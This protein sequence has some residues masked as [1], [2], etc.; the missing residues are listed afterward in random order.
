MTC[1]DESIEWSSLITVV[2]IQEYLFIFL[3]KKFSLFK[4][5]NK[6]YHNQHRYFFSVLV[7]YIYPLEAVGS[8]YLLN[9]TAVLYCQI[10]TNH[11][12]H[13]WDK[14]A[15][16]ARLRFSSVPRETHS[17]KY[18]YISNLQNTV[19]VKE[20]IIDIIVLYR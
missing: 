14:K 11:I 17:C 20:L 18:V 2:H 19:L 9:I 12:Q 8:F 5:R 15:D 13:C 10:V 16:F 4:F 1:F 3:K 6:N 7:D